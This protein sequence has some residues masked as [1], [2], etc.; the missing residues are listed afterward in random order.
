MTLFVRIL[1]LSGCALLSCSSAEVLREKGG[2]S[3]N[4]SKI[5]V[6]NLPI[7]EDVSMMRLVNL[8]LTIG[9]RFAIPID[10]TVRI[11]PP[12]IP[13]PGYEPIPDTNWVRIESSLLKVPSSGDVATDVIIALPDDESLLG[14][15]FQAD[16]IMTTAGNKSFNGIHTGY[17]ITGCLL[18]SVAPVRNAE[19][20]QQALQS[21]ANAAFRL[22]P[23][24]VDVFQ[25][26]PGQ[27]VVL[28]APDGAPLR[29]W[30]ESPTSCPYTL[31]AIPA[32]RSSYKPDP[33]SRTGDPQDVRLG[34]RT[35]TLEPGAAT[36]LYIAIQPPIDADLKAS[37]RLYQ[38]AVRSGVTQGVEQ[39]IKIYLWGQPAPN[40]PPL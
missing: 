10:V 36:N 15:R 12:S 32:E 16:V 30:N 17:E 38:V 20:L 34:F 19:A 35:C 23:P 22:E 14:R 9:N 5:V 2:L 8:P 6:N 40:R 37:P 29:L 11:R 7:G 1:F 24:R 18:F 13:R 31:E 4:Y 27:V 39:Y 28:T 3:A 21:P 25:V 26:S 33:G